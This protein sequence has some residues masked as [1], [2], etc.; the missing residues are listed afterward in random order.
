MLLVDRGRIARQIRW[1]LAQSPLYSTGMAHTSLI[2][3]SIVQIIDDIRFL[4]FLQHILPHTEGD[5]V[6]T[7]WSPHCLAPPDVWG[8]E[9]V[10]APSSWTHSDSDRICGDTPDTGDLHSPSN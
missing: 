7:P 6:S 4:Q 2:L 5:K 9:T 8:E 10:P 3:G 1:L